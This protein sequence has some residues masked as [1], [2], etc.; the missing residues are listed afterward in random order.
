MSLKLR[1]YQDET[2]DALRAGF[3]AGHN[4]QILYSPTGGGKTEMAIA[5]LEA[6]KKKGNRAAMILDRIILTDQT[7]QRLDKY[8]I[9][10]GVLMSG[11]WRYRPYEHIQVCSAQTI[12][13]RGSFPGLSLMI[14]DECHAKRAQTIEFIKNNPEIKVIGLS[15]TPFTK[16]LGDTYTNVVSTVTTKQLV[17]QKVLAPLRV[18]IAKEIDMTGAKKV[19]GEWSSKE[20][21]K[22]GMQITGDIVSEWIKKTHEIYGKPVKTIVFCAG[23]AHGAD[24]SKKFA[25]EGYNFIS[26]S[27]KDDGTF[28]QDVIED[29][30]RPDT[31][32]HGLIA[33]DILTKGFDCVLEGSRVLTDRGLVAIDKVLSTDKIWDGVEFVSHDGVVY[34]G[35]QNV[36]TYAGL[37]A[38]SDH[39]VKTAQ[40]W[41]S[42]GECARLGIPI[43]K[44]GDGGKNLQEHEG[45]FSSGLSFQQEDKQ[46]AIDVRV[47]KVWPFG[48]GAYFNV[49]CSPVGWLFGLRRPTVACSSM[50]V[51]ERQMHEP[52]APVLSGL[53]R[54][55]YSFSIWK[56]KAS[57]SMDSIKHWNTGEHFDRHS[58]GSNRQRWSLRA[59]EFALVNAARKQFAHAAQQIYKAFSFVSRQISGNQVFRQNLEKFDGLWFERRTD[60][61]EVSSTV[62]Q[63]KGKV[64]DILN[65]GPRNSFTCEGLLI[66]NC[67]DVK[68]G[69]SARPFS[70]SLSSHIQQMGRVMRSHADKEYA[71]WLC[72]SGNYLRF[73]EDWEEVYNNGVHELDDAKE[74]AKKE[75]EKKEKEAA[76]C[77]MCSALWP[78]NSDTCLNCGHVRERKNAVQEVAGEMEELAPSA[79]RDVKQD[80][81]GMCHYMV[82]YRGW[83]TGR[84]AHTYKDKFGV[85]PRGLAD[86]PV[87]PSKDFDKAVKAALIKFL[88]TKR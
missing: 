78:S 73:Q 52:I 46:R 18:F 17:D 25:E 38:T 85:W 77:P 81:Y 5:L 1:G 27:Y 69:I 6:A 24:L 22:R 75:K 51:A 58:F 39:K 2:L 9:E 10:H 50:Q 32:I 65:C 20:S 15:A 74:K 72:H 11:H 80:W 35:I 30:A 56:P 8:Q 3:A 57:G 19:A 71:V 66:H 44:T 28:K 42:F 45:Q 26:I 84:A 88:K 60:H 34:K 33:T 13:K 12:E 37:T 40:G 82:K 64:W 48:V 62:R 53:W 21:E 47:P 36:I 76:K 23:V 83:S 54:T 63:T 49:A 55:W 14:V 59:R 86:T 41:T 67:S 68:I 61:R 4:V 29:F 43:I 16:G 70:K 87:L 7:S 31:E 79:S